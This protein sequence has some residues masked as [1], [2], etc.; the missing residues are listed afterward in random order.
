MPSRFGKQPTGRYCLLGDLAM[1]A[2]YDGIASHPGN[3]R[4]VQTQKDV[5]DRRQTPVFLVF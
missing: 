4:T 5:K 3:L 2:K 1:Q